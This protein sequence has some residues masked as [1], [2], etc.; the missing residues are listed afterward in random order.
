MVDTDKLQDLAAG[1]TTLDQVK[2]Y[3][4]DR[5]KA[6]HDTSHGEED[7]DG[8]KLLRF[9][10]CPYKG[11]ACDPPDRAW[12]IV[13]DDGDIVAGCHGGKCAGKGWAHLQ[14]V[15]GL[16]FADYLKGTGQKVKKPKVDPPARMVQLAVKNDTLFHTPEGRGYAMTSR[17]GQNEVLPIRSGEYRNI[18]RLRYEKETGAIPK[19]EHVGNAIEHVDAMAVENGPEHPV[20][21]RVAE[22]DGVIY[23]AQ[24]DKARHVYEVKPTGWGPAPSCPVYFRYSK[25]GRPL[26]E[27]TKGGRL[28][29]L[30]PFVNVR[31][32]DR[33]LLAAFLVHF[34]NPWGPYTI[35]ALFGGPG[36]G[37]TYT[38][39]AIQRTLDP[40]E[41]V[42][43]GMA[44]SAED[45]LI[46]S[47]ERRL[48]V[49]DNL[50]HLTKDESD[51]LCR[52]CTGNAVTRR[53]LYENEDETTFKG[54]T[55]VVITAVSDVIRQ[56]DLWD[57]ALRFVLPPL[58]GPVDE[59]ELDLAYNSIAPAVFGV[60]L[61]G[62]ASALRNLPH[63]TIVDPPRMVG[64]AKWGTA[65][66]EGLG[67]ADGSVMES[68]RRNIGEVADI[69]LESD[70]A[71]KLTRLAEKGFKGRTKQLAETLGLV[72]SA[73]ACKKLLSQ[74]RLLAPAFA[75]KG[76]TVDPDRTLHGSKIVVVEKAS[77]PAV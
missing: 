72:T 26:P 47:R 62:V 41:V 50:D 5:K 76:I 67:L 9:N 4:A 60:L 19:K 35:A 44:R 55:P 39:N 27:P 68:Y 77:G 6:G 33:P 25:S 49:C 54:K 3:L 7:C 30:W 23:V 16:T 28:D 24:G 12:I 2:G 65:A 61:D 52:Q 63:T 59:A 13:N 64:F 43:A 71:Q 73:A 22:H 70:L 46:G 57:R 8:G 36:T 58:S 37:K 42:G 53:T 38:A 15:L 21:L 48:L 40:S 45:L 31:P 11:K 51:N 29:L 32:E 1:P 34:F 75:K 66:E 20:G 17:R 18:T 69:I 56:A 10:I 14:G 74:L